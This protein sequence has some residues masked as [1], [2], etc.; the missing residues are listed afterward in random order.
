M[1]ITRKKKKASIPIK[2][3][4]IDDALCPTEYEEYLESAHWQEHRE[5]V[6]EFWRYRCCL[7]N[8]PDNLHVHHR[9]Y[10]RIGQEDL[11]DNVVLC[12]RCHKMVH[13]ARHV[14]IPR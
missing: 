6:L 2:A 14:R 7:C 12:K 10:E 3:Y 8:S 11:Q 1:S 13:R 4:I 5:K 9:T